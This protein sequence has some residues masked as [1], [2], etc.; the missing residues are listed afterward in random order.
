MHAAALSYV[1]GAL[2]THPSCRLH[3]A[4]QGHWGFSACRHLS[5]SGC[6]WSSFWFISPPR[7]PAVAGLASAHAVLGMGGAY[8]VQDLPH[9]SGP[10]RMS[11][12]VIKCIRV[13]SML[14]IGSH[15]CVSWCCQHN[16]MGRLCMYVCHPTSGR[17][18][19]TPLQEPASLQ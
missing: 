18:L 2:Y 12:L 19:S 10:E 17:V 16:R 6:S 15:R 13:G 14:D 11:G 4:C 5:P 8:A 1:R 7:N 3:W 9:C